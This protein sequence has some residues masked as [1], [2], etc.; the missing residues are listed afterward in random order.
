[1]VTIQRGMTNVVAA[2]WLKDVSVMI[3]ILF[4]EIP[5]GFDVVDL[6]RCYCL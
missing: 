4:C 5:C 6:G 2:E 3:L 1:M